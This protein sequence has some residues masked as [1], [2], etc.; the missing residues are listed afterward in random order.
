MAEIALK[1]NGNNVDLIFEGGISGGQTFPENLSHYQG[2]TLDLSKVAYINSSG[3][4]AWIEWKNKHLSDLKTEVTV[5]NCP[6][7]FVEQMNILINIL[8]R[9][10]VIKSFKVPYY[11]EDDDE[12]VEVTYNR[13]EHFSGAEVKWE[14]TMNI[15]GKEAEIDIEPKSYFKFLKEYS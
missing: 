11:I 1:E 13:E 3:I 14:S 12:I 4:K 2:I 6:E 8:P 7:C 5:E 15:D 9:H 10:V